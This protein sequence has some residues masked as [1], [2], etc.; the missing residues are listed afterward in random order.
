MSTK[1]ATSATLSLLLLA[2]ASY[3]GEYRITPSAAISEEYTDNVFDTVNKKSDYITR[4]M[5][6]VAMDMK[7]PVFDGNLNYMFDYR[8]YA[9]KSREHD[10]THVL[11]ARGR[12][13]LIDN[14]FAIEA[15]DD[16]QRV[17]LDF[18][19]DVTQESLFANQSDR[20]VA[21]VSPTFTLRPLQTLTLTTGYRFTDTRYFGSE[22]IDKQDHSGFLNG[23]YELSDRWHATF[24]YTFVH[25][26]SATD[27][28][29]EHQGYVGF[30]YEYANKSFIFGQG[31]SSWLEYA[32]GHKLRDPYWNAGAT[33][34]FDLVTA[35][36]T[37]GVRYDENPLGD[38]SKESF[39]TAG[40]ERQ[41]K[42]GALGLNLGYSEFDQ[43]ESSTLQ[44][45]KY[46]A[47]VQLHNEI[48]SRLNGKLSFTAE[49]YQ[50]ALLHSYT[51]RFQFEAGLGYEL[52]K[53]LTASLDYYL[54][55][56]YS[57]GIA[58]DNRQVNRCILG[59]RM[60]F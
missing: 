59:L 20:N 6:G 12:L 41:L 27:G 49:K 38:V 14:F 8:Y 21:T 15:S 1:L 46:S 50:Q 28:F 13:N 35:T 7:S 55:D 33:H 47:T 58:T 57:P 51:R 5:P 16:Y 18:T 30:R 11:A 48:L 3:A 60:T 23:S 26:K 19:R 44:T 31:G 42:K 24:G 22:G 36:L 9:R 34:S 43:A 25:E 37:T 2:S 53:Q 29:D 4:A 17:S 40:V 56:Y 54:T 39:A 45:R 32:D 52:T 10:L